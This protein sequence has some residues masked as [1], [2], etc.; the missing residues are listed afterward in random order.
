VSSFR[1]TMNRSVNDRKTAKS[2]GLDQLGVRNVFI[3]Y[4]GHHR[5]VI[6]NGFNWAVNIQPGHYNGYAF[7]F[8]EDLS[9]V[10]GAHQIGWGVNFIHTNM[11]NSSNSTITIKSQRES[12][13]PLPN[14]GPVA[15]S[16]VL[17]AAA[18]SNT[19]DSTIDNTSYPLRTGPMHFK[20]DR[21]IAFFQALTKG[22][23]TRLAKGDLAGGG[24]FRI[25]KCARHKE[26]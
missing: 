7:Q 10:R 16:L 9:M 11:N 1:A 25:F 15:S 12:K 8:S 6:Q 14:T 19:S 3:P 18:A 4:P 5:M 2:G 13:N 23:C 20:G 26:S 24:R 22:S 21:T 17:S